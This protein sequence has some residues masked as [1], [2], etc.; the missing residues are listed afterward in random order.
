[1]DKPL[2][3]HGDC[4]RL[5]DCMPIVT[6]IFADPPDN[7]DLSYASYND[8]RQEALYLEWM[9][10]W[11][12]RALPRC[13]ILWVSFN[14]RWLAPMGSIAERLLVRYPQFKFKPCVQT[15]T[16][17]QHN[18]NDLANNYRPLW[19]FQWHT[20]Q[21]YPDDIRV[22]SWRLQ[23]GDKRAS[24]NGRVPGDV[25]DFPR[26]TGNSKQRRPWHPTQLHEGLVERCI[27]LTTKKNDMVI[28]PFAGTGTTLRVAQ[29]IG[30]R[31]IGIEICPK[32]VKKMQEE[33]KDHWCFQTE[34]EYLSQSAQST[35]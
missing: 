11:L 1:M 21:L 30:R 33:W 18:D 8:K 20:S 19:R 17:G 28:D 14:S 25:F 24:P 35:Q 2:L 32:Y 34:A 23:H 15:F 6:C 31:V 22:E 7:I 9:E 27:R 16:F 13:S 10:E 26:V 29:M 12:K 4:V 3:I 5:L